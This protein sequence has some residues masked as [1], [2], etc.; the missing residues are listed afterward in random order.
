MITEQQLQILAEPFGENRKTEY[1]F[2]GYKIEVTKCGDY[3]D[4]EI[5]YQDSYMG[6]WHSFHEDTDF[7]TEEQAV[8]EAKSW[9]DNYDGP[10][11]DYYA[12]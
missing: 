2:N 10:G 11:D 3:F 5:F 1:L 9:I 4:Y 7:E 8:K 6:Y 12:Q